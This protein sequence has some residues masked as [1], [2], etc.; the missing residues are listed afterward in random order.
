MNL[1]Q[2]R[3]HEVDETLTCV[4]AVVV[5]AVMTT[6]HVDNV[7]SCQTAADNERCAQLL[8]AGRFAHLL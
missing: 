6:T 7:N 4:I 8:P 5:E 3:H 1:L 2:V